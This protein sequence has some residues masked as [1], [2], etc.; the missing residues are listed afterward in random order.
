MTIG[1]FEIDIYCLYFSTPWSTE[2]NQ[3]RPY[4]QFKSCL[5]DKAS[6]VQECQERYYPEIIFGF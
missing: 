6:G 4:D 1:Y 5:R 3:R 2:K